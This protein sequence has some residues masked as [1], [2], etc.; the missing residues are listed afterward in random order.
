MCIR[1][2]GTSNEYEQIFKRI[3]SELQRCQDNYEEMLV[4]LLRHLLISFHREL[5][6]EH[7]LKNEYLDHE[8]DN[9]VTFFRENYNQNIN[10]D[11]YAASRD[12]SVS[13]FIR[14]FKKYT[15]STPMQFIVGIRINNAQ[16][17]L[18]LLYTSLKKNRFCKKQLVN[19]CV[20]VLH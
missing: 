1:D 13:W 20:Q 14:N 3:I 2:R 10:I 12:M 11:D 18:C 9:A 19:T 8:M 17:L 6:R 4:L 5:T 15:G 16:M 7:I